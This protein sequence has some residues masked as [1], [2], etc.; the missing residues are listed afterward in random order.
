M[1]V[2]LRRH[3]KL[4]APRRAIARSVEDELVPGLKGQPGFKGYR[5]FATDDGGAASV[6]AFG[7]EEAADLSAEKARRWIARHPDF[8]PERAEEFSGGCVAHDARHGRERRPGA[9]REAPYVLVR[10]LE[11]VPELGRLR[12]IARR[13][14]RPLIARAEGF[15]GLYV[16]G[17]G[18]R[19][20]RAAVVTLFDNR[21]NAI[22]SHEQAAR[23]LRDDLPEIKVA[24]VVHGPTVVMALAS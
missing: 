10:E 2:I 14:T 9:G 1:H 18:G 22:A 12:E 13:K 24:R 11:G 16:V 21:R 19:D 15:R 7:T 6:G 8:F 20:R 17:S 23:V 3:A 4:G 5:A